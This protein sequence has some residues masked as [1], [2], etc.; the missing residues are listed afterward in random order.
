MPPGRGRVPGFPHM[1][2]RPAIAGCSGFHRPDARRHRPG[3]NPFVRQS[4]AR[5]LPDPAN[6]KQGD[7]FSCG[8]PR[9]TSAARLVVEF[10]SPRC[11]LTTWQG[12]DATTIAIVP[13]DMHGCALRVESAP[14]RPVLFAR[15]T[16]IT[17]Y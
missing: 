17:G 11:M 16:Q 12:W 7:R 13:A 9:T 1:S 14:V 8:I 4:T 5:R 2:H 15:K 3:H 10:E 6:T